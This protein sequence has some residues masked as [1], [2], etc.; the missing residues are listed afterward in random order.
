MRR[1][2]TEPSEVR[3]KAANPCRQE[4][5][6]TPPPP[7]KERRRGRESEMV[8][9]PEQGYLR[10]LPAGLRGGQTYGFRSGTHPIKIQ[11]AISHI[12]GTLKTS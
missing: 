4:P 2:D 8:A 10:H 6:H 12:L 11:R 9:P 5:M 7:R 3:E 1:Q